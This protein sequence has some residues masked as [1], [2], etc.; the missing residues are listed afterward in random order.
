VVSSIEEITDFPRSKAR[1]KKIHISAVEGCWNNIGRRLAEKGG[2]SREAVGG[3]GP[4]LWGER[5]KA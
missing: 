5:D 4:Y 3:R 2:T 1:G